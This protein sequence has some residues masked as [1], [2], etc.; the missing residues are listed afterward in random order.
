MGALSGRGPAKAAAVGIELAG[1]PCDRCRL[2]PPAENRDPPCPRQ[3]PQAPR[4]TRTNGWPQGRHQS[5]RGSGPARLTF[6]LA[7]APSAAAGPPRLPRETR[8]RARCGARF[9]RRRRSGGPR[10]PARRGFRAARGVRPRPRSPAARQMRAHAEEN[11]TVEKPVYHFGLSLWRARSVAASRNPGN[12]PAARRP[13]ADVYAGILRASCRATTTSQASYLIPI[14]GSCM[15]PKQSMHDPSAFQ[16]RE[17]DPESLGPALRVW[18]I[19]GLPSRES[20]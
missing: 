17:R 8:L 18:S 13:S 19:T 14:I 7:P 12:S 9:R 3:G 4:P 5:G 10:P 16:V 15:G 1:R 6:P 11:R 20:R 2:R